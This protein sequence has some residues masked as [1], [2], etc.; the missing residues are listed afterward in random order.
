MCGPLVGSLLGG[1]AVDAESLEWLLTDING[2]RTKLCVRVLQLCR[3]RFRFVLL[4]V[5]KTGD[6]V[7]LS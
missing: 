4:E 2:R 6:V 5:W 7:S 3:S 1:G